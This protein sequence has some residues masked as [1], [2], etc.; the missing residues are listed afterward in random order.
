VDVILN[1]IHRC[2]TMEADPEITI[3]TN[4]ADITPLYLRDLRNMGINRLN[5]GIQSFD[6]P[7]LR[8]LGRRHIAADALSAIETAMASGFQNT[9]IDLIYGVPGQEMDVWDHT[10]K[11]AVSFHLPHLSCYQLTIEPGTPLGASLR[12]KKFVAPTEDRQYEF[13]MKTADTLEQAGYI[14]YEVSNFAASLPLTSRHNQKYWDHTA[15]LGLGPAA[16][17][18]RE[19]RRWWNLSN[20]SAYLEAFNEGRTPVDSSESLT[21]EELYFESI[22]LGLRTRKGINLST[23]SSLYGDQ[24]WIGNK[25]ILDRLLNEGFLELSDGFLKPTRRGLAVAD[26][27]ALL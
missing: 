19:G 2:F 14:H 24:T 20:V 17:S 9:G 22:F 12:H 7:V 5:I 6:D 23:L 27:L 1:G 13:F 3:E 16:H 26:T 15:Y 25:A 10:L 4:P 11:T 18:F 8:F 21:P